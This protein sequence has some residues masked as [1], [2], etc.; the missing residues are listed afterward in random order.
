MVGQGNLGDFMRVIT[1]P[2]KRVLMG[3][4]TLLIGLGSLLFAATVTATTAEAA[5]PPIEQRSATTVTADALPTVQ[6]DGVVWDQE[7][8]GDT[9]Y[10]GGQFSYARPAGAAAGANQVARTNLLAYNIRTGELI[11]SFAPTLNGQVKTIAKSPDGSRL[12]V[13]GSFTRS[14]GPTATGWPRSA[15]PPA[16]W[17]PTSPRA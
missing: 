6:I 15:P 12:Y 11:T 7:I 9:V 17:S 8:V 14:T 4:I 1:S 3:I 2:V 10:A 13:G 5:V 16:R